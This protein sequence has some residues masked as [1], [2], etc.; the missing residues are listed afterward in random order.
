M[1]AWVNDVYSAYSRSQYIAATGFGRDRATAEGNALASVSAFFGQSVQIERVAASSYQQAIVNGV[2]EG[3]IDTAEMRS[4]IKSTA[5]MDNLM[6]VEIKEVWFD[7]RNTYYAVA[8]MEKSNAIAIYTRLIQA[9]LN[10]INNLITMTPAEKNS[11]SGAIRYRF[12]AAVADVNTSYH[13]VVVLLEGRPITSVTSGD[14]YRVEAQNI[15]KTI[16]IGIRVD[17]DRNGRLFSAFARCFADWGFEAANA[18]TVSN[19]RY[20]LDV[21]AALSPVNLPNN[22]NIFSRI[23]LTTSL[24][25]TNLGIVLVPY[26]FN[27]REGHVTQ[28]EAENRAF[29]AAER[30][31]NDVFASLLSDYLTQLMPRN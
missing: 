11:L 1:P 27:S 17:N 30:N 25:D 14:S 20:V 8:V 10:V 19:I 21:R 22:S 9:N 28:A 12:A 6:G 31:I 3:W 29:T 24:T 18:N 4:N 15:I 23:E 26:S 13:N 16:P 2:M 5:F 7:S